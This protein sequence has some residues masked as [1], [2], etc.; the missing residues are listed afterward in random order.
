MLQHLDFF[1]PDHGTTCEEDADPGNAV[2]VRFQVPEVS[3]VKAPFGKT[4]IYI[5]NYHFEHVHQS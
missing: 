1:L 5:E 3:W 2:G 4:N